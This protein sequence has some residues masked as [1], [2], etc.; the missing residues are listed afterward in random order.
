MSGTVRVIIFPVVF[1]ETCFLGNCV[2][3]ETVD[4]PVEKKTDVTFIQHDVF[5]L[6]VHLKNKLLCIF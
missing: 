2:I 6:Q 4:G 3:G 5:S 1:T